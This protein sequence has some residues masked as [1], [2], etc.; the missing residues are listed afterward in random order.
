MA[1]ENTL[2]FTS[3]A[4]R[5]LAFALL[6]AGVGALLGGC[7]GLLQGDAQNAQGQPIFA[8]QTGDAPPLYSD[9]PEEEAERPVLKRS[10]S[11]SLPAGKTSSVELVAT[12]QPT[13]T[14]ASATQ[15]A[16]LQTLAGSATAYRMGAGDVLDV[17]ISGLW[18][19][20]D[21]RGQ[22]ALNSAGMLNLGELGTYRLQGLS[23]AQA[24]R[25]LRT[26]LEKNGASPQ[27]ALRIDQYRS[28]SVRLQGEVYAPGDYFIDE[29]AMS[30]AEAI[31][32][33]GGLLEQADLGRIQLQRAGQSQNLNLRQ[34]YELGLPPENVLL[35]AGDVLTFLPKP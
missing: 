5:K 32:R 1:L 35:R 4:A 3:D 33:A 21:W 18:Q 7:A 14:P 10:L 12:Q 22:V 20:P 28:Q 30:L 19:R 34:L 16:Q 17:D 2:T 6:L 29:Q 13:Q 26:A 11:L 9:S 23:V 24:Q 25:V 15:Q 31:T 8:A 27:V